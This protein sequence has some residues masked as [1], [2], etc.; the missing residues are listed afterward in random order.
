MRERAFHAGSGGEV[1]FQPA[2]LD[3]PVWTKRTP[4]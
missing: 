3:I 1:E 4:E 2:I